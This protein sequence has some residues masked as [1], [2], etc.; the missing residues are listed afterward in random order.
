MGQEPLKNTSTRKSLPWSPLNIKHDP[1]PEAYPAT[2]TDWSMDRPFAPATVHSKASSLAI[3]KA[4]STLGC[5]PLTHPFLCFQRTQGPKITM[6]LKPLLTWPTTR[7]LEIRHQFSK[8]T[9]FGYI[10]WFFMKKCTVYREL[11]LTKLVM[12][13]ITV[14]VHS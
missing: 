13:L 12:N 14:R 11:C 3:Q 5:K 6:E 4:P 2:A 1:L 7:W 10:S 8:L 9:S